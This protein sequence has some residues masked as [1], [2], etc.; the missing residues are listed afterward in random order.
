MKKYF[1]N[2]DNEIKKDLYLHL[3]S[4]LKNKIAVFNVWAPNAESISV[5][6]DFNDWVIGKDSLS[7]L[8]SGVWHGKV[9]GL[10]EFENDG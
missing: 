7:K 5:V 6:G 8:C 4:F 9:S 2:F 3:G 10:K 1:E